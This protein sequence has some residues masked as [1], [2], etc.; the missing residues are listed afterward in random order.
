MP[1]MADITVKAAN[2]TTDVVLKA[3]APSF[4]DKSDAIWNI[5]ASSTIRNH[6]PVFTSQTLWNGTKN[7]ATR[8][9][10]SLMAGRS[11][12]RRC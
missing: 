4:G 6:R 11:H 12:G 10:P 9:R 8:N 1:T 3:K 2:G 7:G 5:D